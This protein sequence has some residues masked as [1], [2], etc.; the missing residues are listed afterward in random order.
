M[1]KNTMWVYDAETYPNIFTI[2]LV[3]V[4]SLE[5]RAY[6]ISDLRDD[7]ASLLEFLAWL[8]AVDHVLVGFNNLGFDYPVLHQFM[9]TPLIGCAGLYEK[10]MSI[11][12]SDD[13]FGHIIWDSEVFIRQI[14]LYKIYH[15]DN[16]AKST[17]LKMLEFNMRSKVIQDL[18]YKPGTWLD[19]NAQRELL[20]YNLKDCV[21]TLDFLNYSWGAI[22]F[23][24][25]L[26]EKYNRN[27]M[28]HNDTKIGKD[29]FINELEKSAPGICYTK[30]PSGKVMNQTPRPSILLGDCLFDYV[31][32]TTP[33]F[34]RVHQWLKNK[35]ITSTKGAFAYIE[36]GVDMVRSM[37]PSR[38]KVFGLTTRD[39]DQLVLNITPAKIKLGVNLTKC[40]GVIARG[41]ESSHLRFVVGNATKSGLH[42][43]INGF[44]YDFGTGGIHGSVLS[45]TV[46][47]DDK[48][49]IID[50]DVTSYY[51]SITIKNRIYPEHLSELFCDI[52]EG[53][54][55]Q[56]QT[57]SK[58]EF[59]VDNAIL[60]L[61][62][63]GVSGDSN[64]PHSPLYDPKYT[65]TVTLNGQL[66][67]CMLA[68]RLSVIPELTMIQINTDGLSVKLP[69]CHFGWYN[70]LCKEWEEFTK[71]TL[72]YVEYSKMF[73][74]DVNNYLAV[75]TDGSVKRKGAYEYLTEEDGGTLGWHK[76][77]SQL[78]VPMV[79]ERHLLYGMDIK[80]M[81][82]NHP[83]EYDF[84][85][86]TKVKR[87]CELELLDDEGERVCEVQRITR[88][89][90]ANDGFTLNKKS[91]PPEGKLEGGWKR[92]NGLTDAFFGQHSLTP[93]VGDLDEHGVPHN[94]LIHTGNKSKYKTGNT[95]LANG[96]LV[97]ECND[98]DNFERGYLDYEYYIN[99]VNKLVD[100]IKSRVI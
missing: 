43:V 69:R 81:I 10:A 47:S 75:S 34:W 46:L 19:S 9:R 65:M 84:M 45:S 98:M 83:D 62:L 51:P 79:A 38:V 12:N 31:S 92:K 39:C 88:Y 13:R 27:L 74:R 32:F 90:I 70:Q 91:P 66:M 4:E 26:S 33:E 11:I 86:R 22:D 72:E 77:R 87:N 56:R 6:V 5:V 16:S 99:E 49:M 2:T 78:V 17:G 95:S 41:F 53:L 21:E 18:P 1:N 59:P 63:N 29:L 28:N 73:I 82:E 14:D 60:K 30:T 68:E 76:N 44:E 35:T 52:Y 25:V 8:R 96:Y 94:P 57:R 89:H 3:N 23:R 61:A 80:S 36:V 15:F 100:P 93:V 24:E 71:L 40:E 85:L 37:N 67:L 97:R 20:K 50:A 55:N 58:K 7:S 64:S 42:T 54:F 48:Y